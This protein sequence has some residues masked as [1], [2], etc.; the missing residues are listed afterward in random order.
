MAFLS[1][2]LL[3]FSC[4]VIAA[5][6][7]ATTLPS[8]ICV[9]VQTLMNMANSLENKLENFINYLEQMLPGFIILELFKKILQALLTGFDFVGVFIETALCGGF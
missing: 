4:N 9:D 8:S 5:R 1:F 7:S 6:A 3:F 2:L